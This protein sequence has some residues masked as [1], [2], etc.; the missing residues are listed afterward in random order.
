MTIARVGTS[1]NQLVAALEREV[2]PGLLL[3]DSATRARLARITAELVENFPEAL[4]SAERFQSQC[5]RALR[6]DERLLRAGIEG[7]VVLVTGGTGCIGSAL[8]GELQGL[9]PSRLVSLS[10]GVTAAAGPVDAVEYLHADI[11]DEAALR[12]VFR[13]VVPDVVF[14]LAAQRDP[15][16]AERAVAESLDANIFGTR[17]VLSLSPRRSG[18]EADV[19][20][21]WKSACPFTP[22][23]YAA[24]KKFGEVLALAA[25]HGGAMRVGVVR[26]THVVDNSLVWTRFRSVGSGDVLRVHDPSTQFYTQSARE[27]AQ[28]LL[29]SNVKLQPCG[30]ADVLAIRDLGLPTDL[31]DLALAVVSED[32]GLRPIYVAAYERGYEDSVSTTRSELLLRRSRLPLTPFL[33]C[34]ASLRAG[35]S[36][37]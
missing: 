10:R 2:P 23:V 13:D 12:R 36:R 22:H 18:R 3:L 34:T 11:T 30:A 31:L 15:G 35:G 25:A 29:W 37:S 1:R 7:R 14:H 21:D 26:F 6:L 27:A 20:V 9:E 16:L 19:R 17:N 8:L 24:S 28:L 5:H 4:S 32:S 33:T